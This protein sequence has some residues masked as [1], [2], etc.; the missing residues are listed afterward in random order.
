VIGMAEKRAHSAEIQQTAR[1]HAPLRPTIDERAA[2]FA[3]YDR[4]VTPR[5]TLETSS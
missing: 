1:A 5:R 2:A 3:A 4:R